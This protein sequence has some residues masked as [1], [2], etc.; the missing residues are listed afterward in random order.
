MG[1]G[2]RVASGLCVAA[3]G[4]WVLSAAAGGWFFVK[5]WTTQGAD[6]RT[7]ILL[8]ASER[9]QILGRCGNSSSLWML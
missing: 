6:G 2:H 4:L 9:D 5:G 1:T 8:A 7:E 3:V